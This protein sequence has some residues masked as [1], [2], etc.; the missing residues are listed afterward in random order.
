MLCFVFSTIS[1]DLISWKSKKHYVVARRSEFAHFSRHRVSGAVKRHVMSQKITYNTYSCS[2]SGMS[3]EMMK[4]DGRDSTKCRKYKRR[5][6]L[7][8]LESLMKGKRQNCN[9]ASSLN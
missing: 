1:K 7:G 3:R 9:S 2:I 6:M 4:M 5:D 8:I